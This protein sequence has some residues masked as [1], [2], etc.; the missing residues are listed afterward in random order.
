MRLGKPVVKSVK[1]PVC[2]STRQMVP[3]SG[4]V[5]YNALSGPTVLPWSSSRPV[6][7]CFCKL[8]GADFAFAIE[9]SKR[10]SSELP[11][12]ISFLQD[13]VIVR[14]TNPTTTKVFDIRLIKKKII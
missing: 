4:A 13:E 10:V 12:R 1:A 7:N 14:R 9:L 5:T 11:G 2:G 6:T 8:G 3:A